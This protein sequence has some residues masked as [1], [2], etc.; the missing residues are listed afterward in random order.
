MIVPLHYSL[1]LFLISK[2]F[3][4]GCYSRNKI[5][6][7]SLDPLNKS[8]MADIIKQIFTNKQYHM[9]AL[10]HIL[11][12]TTLVFTYSFSNSTMGLVRFVRLNSIFV[13]V[14][15]GVNLKL[16]LIHNILKILKKTDITEIKQRHSALYW[17]KLS[18]RMWIRNA[19]DRTTEATSKIRLTRASQ[20]KHYAHYQTSNFMHIGRYEQTIINENCQ[21]IRH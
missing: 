4:R 12:N 14:S 6:K 5:F 7:N 10:C 18:L 15:F 17:I 16:T 20:T 3:P 11:W 8:G 2:Q 19:P 1:H 21:P 9:K 13:D